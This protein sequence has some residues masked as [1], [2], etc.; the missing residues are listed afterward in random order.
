ME[1]SVAPFSHG[2]LRQSRYA[3]TMAIWSDPNHGKS[4]L[5]RMLHTWW[6][7]ARGD[8]DVPDRSDLR[9]DEM[10]RL[11]AFMFIADAEHEPFRVRYRLVGTRAVEVTGFDITGHYLDELLSAEPDQPWIDHYRRAYVDRKPLLGATTVPTTAGSMLTYE[12]GIFPLRKGG[13]AID[14]FVAVED[15]FGLI[16]RV[17]QVEPWRETRSHLPAAEDRLSLMPRPA[18]QLDA[19]YGLR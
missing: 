16:S 19:R 13:Q 4:E 18:N 1:E 5:V 12:F 17:V 6:E 10:K 9:P 14:Q 7:A 15:Y 11:L 2:W 8:A 3:V